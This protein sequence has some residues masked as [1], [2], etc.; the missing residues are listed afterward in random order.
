M[1]LPTSV[2][3]VQLAMHRRK[4]T[5]LYFLLPLLNQFLGLLVHYDPLLG[6]N[7]LHLVV[8]NFQVD[9]VELVIVHLF[10][11]QTDVSFL[12]LQNL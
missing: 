12:V 3:Q 6:S 9:W 4:V 11:V 7:A 8:F 5:R 2:Y 10:L 1:Q